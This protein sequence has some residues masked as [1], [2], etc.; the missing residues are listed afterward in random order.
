[1]FVRNAVIRAAFLA[2]LTGL[3]VPAFAQ[4]QLR[5]TPAPPAM[6]LP[7]FPADG[8]Y[9]Y[10]ILRGDKP[11]GT[12]QVIVAR[13]D[14]NERIDLFE[15]GSYE[16]VSIGRVRG[17]LN[18]LDLLPVERDAGYP[19]EPFMAAYFAVPSIRDS[20]ASDDRLVANGASP[21]WAH[22]LAEPVT[23]LYPKAASDDWPNDVGLS[24]ADVTLY[25]DART[26]VVHE[27]LFKGGL[28]TR[29]IAGR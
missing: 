21:F 26:G 10:T 18:R 6:V 7:P 19:G 8:T 11:V 13:N 24:I 15:S 25:Y 16:G 12:T 22:L 14:A 27:A 23:R 9:S 20:T 5:A 17:S 4:A 2:A 3:A 29:L 1:M 28:R